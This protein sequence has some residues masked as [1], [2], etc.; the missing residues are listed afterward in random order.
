MPRSSQ[1]ESSKAFTEVIKV[2]TKKLEVRDLQS[3][4]AQTQVL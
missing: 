3:L 2:G 1:P 4:E